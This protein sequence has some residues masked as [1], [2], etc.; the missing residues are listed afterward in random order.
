VI[1]H[2]SGSSVDTLLAVYTG[3]E[4]LSLKLV[5][6]NDDD[7]RGGTSSFVRFQAQQGAE[8]QIA[9]DTFGGQE[10]TIALHLEFEAARPVVRASLSEQNLVLSWPA[11]ALGFV[12]EAADTLG[13]GLWA[14][15]S[16]TP[17]NAGTELMV[18]LPL[19]NVHRFYRL[20]RP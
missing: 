13:S 2:T 4:L 20:R 10:G 18:R 7:P 5:A 1:L 14:G 9:V 11:D 17:L 12:L 15:V 6:S 3:T 16:V 8:Y 19:A